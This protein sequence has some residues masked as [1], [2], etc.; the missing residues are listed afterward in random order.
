[1]KR[2][3]FQMF[4]FILIFFNMGICESE[5]SENSSHCCI[6]CCSDECQVKI[7]VHG[8]DIRPPLFFLKV[9]DSNSFAYHNPFICSIDRPPKYQS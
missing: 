8:S 3:V 4:L 2:M 9:L 1:M 6:I 7:S 5:Y